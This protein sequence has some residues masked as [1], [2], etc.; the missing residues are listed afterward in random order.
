MLWIQGLN[1]EIVY[2]VTTYDMLDESFI[3]V[4]KTPLQKKKRKN[5]SLQFRV[6]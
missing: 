1:V 2:S 5:L 3:G 6:S 4:E